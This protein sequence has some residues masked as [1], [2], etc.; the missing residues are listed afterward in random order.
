ML[1]GR[2]AEPRE[3][4]HGFDCQSVEWDWDGPAGESGLPCNCWK[5]ALLTVVPSSSG[6]DVVGSYNAGFKDGERV[7]LARARLLL[8]VQEPQDVLPEDAG[9]PS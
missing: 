3:F 1:V 8:G 6:G 2:V 5:S 4:D 7:A 9:A